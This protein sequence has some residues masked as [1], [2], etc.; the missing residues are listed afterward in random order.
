MGPRWRW[1]LESAGLGIAL[2]AMVIFAVV[3]AGWMFA[4]TVI[5][6]WLLMLALM[7]M[8]DALDAGWIFTLAALGISVAVG[9]GQ[10]GLKAIL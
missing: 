2:G 6:G 7:G 8:H 9:V 10:E 4:L 3:G 5:C 1:V